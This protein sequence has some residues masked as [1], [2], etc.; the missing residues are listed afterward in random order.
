MKFYKYILASALTLAL[1][2]AFVSCGDDELGETI[3]P[4]VTDTVDPNSATYKFDTW[5][6]QNFRD[7]YNL[8]F[9][10]KMIDVEA[11]MNYNLVPASFDKA[12][13]LALLTK[14]LWFDSYKELATEEFLKEHGPRIIHLIGSPAY[15]PQTGTIILGLAEG[16]IKVSL[17][18]VNDLD[19]NDFAQLNEYYFRTMHH[20][21]AHIMHQTK[22]YPTEF[23]TLSNG[24]YDQSNWQDRNGGI[25]TSLGF[26]TN[27]ASSETREDFAETIAN[28]VTRTDEQDQFL[29]WCADQNWFSGDDETDQSIAY[30]YYYYKNEQAQVDND[31]TYTL[32]FVDDKVRNLMTVVDDKKNSYS[33]IAEVEAY[34]ASMEAKG[35]K[36]YP[37]EI[38]D[39]VDGRAIIEQKRNIARNWFKDEWGISFDSLRSIVQ[40]RQANFDIEALRQEIENIQ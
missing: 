29:L 31:R 5:L 3:F 13:D 35:F 27:Y 28:Y 12:R 38:S 40:Y 1:S 25:V 15:N 9:C 11:D 30:C 33:S 2:P 14:Y 4:D 39:E 21:F 19:V 24:R 16:G 32:R 37:Y 7:I 10:Y 6:N 17:F 26:I 23:N 22:S 8:N 36:M 20:E 34:I 18:R